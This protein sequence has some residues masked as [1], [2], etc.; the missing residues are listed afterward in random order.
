MFLG[1]AVTYISLLRF[2]TYFFFKKQKTKDLK[3]AS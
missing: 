1:F 2:M 3:N